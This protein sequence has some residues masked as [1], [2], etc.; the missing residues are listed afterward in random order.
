MP[1]R[2]KKKTI[3]LGAGSHGVESEPPPFFL[4][5]NLGLNRV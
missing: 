1:L 4:D 3:P 2:R 5:T